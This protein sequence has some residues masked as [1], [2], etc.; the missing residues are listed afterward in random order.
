MRSITGGRRKAS[1]LAKRFCA[2][3]MFTRGRRRVAGNVVS[4][5]VFGSILYAVANLNS[6][7]VVVLGHTSCERASNVL[8]LISVTGDSVDA[9]G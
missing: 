9:V 8:A 7:L 5:H 4:Q 2:D 3:E 6:R 1:A